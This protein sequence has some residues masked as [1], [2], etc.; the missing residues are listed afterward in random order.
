MNEVERISIVRLS[1]MKSALWNDYNVKGGHHENSAMW[2]ECKTK[3]KYN[4][5]KVQLERGT[6]WQSKICI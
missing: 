2:K 5:K 4:M 3:K 6:V 1:F